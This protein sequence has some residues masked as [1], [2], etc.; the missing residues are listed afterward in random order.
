MVIR[1]ALVADPLHLHGSC[2][3]S[4]LGMEDR[5]AVSWIL[6][7]LFL[8]W[9]QILEEAML[10]DMSCLLGSGEVP[11]LFTPDEEADIVVRVRDAVRATGKPDTRVSRTVQHSPPR[12]TP[13]QRQPLT[14]TPTTNHTCP[15]TQQ[16]GKKKKANGHENQQVHLVTYVCFRTVGTFIPHR[17][18]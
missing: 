12:H 10:E 14:N 2:Q 3:D 11:N 18:K 7:F 1:T 13:P 9:P 6:L 4:L 15:E 5:I 8:L 17:C 16:H